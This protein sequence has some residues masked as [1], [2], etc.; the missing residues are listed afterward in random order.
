M[1]GIFFI[2]RISKKGIRC[3]IL[4]PTTMMTRQGKRIKMDK[5]DALVI[6]QRLAY[7]VY[8]AV[9]IPT[10]KDDDGIVCQFR[11]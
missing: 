2:S 8:Q 1:P 11:V 6:A 7:G 9:H 4:V 3:T 5:R 10:D